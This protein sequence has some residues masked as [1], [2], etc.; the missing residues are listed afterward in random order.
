MNHAVPTLKK[1]RSAMLALLLAEGLAGFAGAQEAAPAVRLGPVADSPSPWYVGASQGFTHSSNVYSV[2]EGSG[3]TWSSTSLL[4]GFDQRISRQRVFG[5]ATVSANRYFDQ[6]RLNNASYDVALGAN[7]ETV[8]NLSG[9]L[10]LGLDQSLAAPAASAGT[11][12]ARKNLARTETFG[13]KVR[14]GGVSLLTLEAGYDYSRLDYS[15]P[16]YASAETRRDS[17]SLALYYRPGGPLRLG[18][19]VRVDRTR[20]PEALIDPVSGG[21]EANTVHGRHLDLFADYD[22]TGALLVN[23]RLSYTR[24]RNS[25]LGNAD[26]TGVTGRLG[27]IWKA[28]GK[29]TL[30]AYVARDAGFDVASSTRQ[31]FAFSGGTFAST[32]VTSFYENNRITD[33]AEVGAAWAATARIGVN[34]G[35]RYSRAKLSTTVGA[36]AGGPARPDSTDVAQGVFVGATYE[37][38]RNW[39]AACSGSHDTRHVSGGV[40]YSY[41]VNTVGCSTRYLWR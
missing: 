9:D 8:A 25:A 19:G 11:P 21:F 20:S 6:A 2:P 7:W 27:A 35:A 12:V 29:I 26:F 13:S 41:S 33:S 14:W 23:S 22:V 15:A 30:N 1:L 16:E 39:T 32:P 18:V 37:I 24:Q 4:A 10:N 5:S 31:T 34:A 3:D 28:T 40:E 17:G 36:I 38:G